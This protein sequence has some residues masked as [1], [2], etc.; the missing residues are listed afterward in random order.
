MRQP[1]IRLEDVTKRF[2]DQRGAERDAL[3]GVTLDV[4]EAEFV[5]LVGPSGCGKSTILN[6]VAGFERPTTGRVLLD[7]REVVGAD[8]SRICM[9]QS[10]A[11]FPWRTVLANVEYGL[12]VRGVARRERRDVA[13]GYVDLVG[14]AEFAQHRPH[15]LSGGMQQRVALARALAVDPRCLL[16]DEPLGSLDAMTRMRLQEEIARLAQASAKTV[17]FVTHDVDEA[18]FL[19]DRI[20]VLAPSP[21]QIRTI[22]SNRLPRPRARTSGRFL[23]LRAQ[24]FGELERMHHEHRE[25]AA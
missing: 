4:E 13:R 2:Q 18:V 9:F 15:Q 21:G 20:V 8:A 14:L 7:G 16:M 23:A 1:W 25:L 5:C 10:F 3:R 6:L 12:E 22:I 17:V 24:L 19:A 11:L